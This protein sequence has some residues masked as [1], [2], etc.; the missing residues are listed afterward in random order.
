MERD[1]SVLDWKIDSNI[2]E[3]LERLLCS[4]AQLGLHIFL[5]SK[6]VLNDFD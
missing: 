1:V 4:L 5:Q 2:W 6:D 3:Q